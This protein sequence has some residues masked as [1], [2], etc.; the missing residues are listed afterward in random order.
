M[1][2]VHL[3]ETVVSSR[4]SMLVERASGTKRAAE[5]TLSVVEIRGIEPLTS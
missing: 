4:C 5:A 1:I 3:A 2:Y